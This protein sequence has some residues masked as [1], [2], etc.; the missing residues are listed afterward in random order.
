[1]V[2]VVASLHRGGLVFD[3]PGLS[4][5]KLSLNWAGVHCSLNVDQPLDMSRY[6]QKPRAVLHLKENCHKLKLSKL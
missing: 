2:S 5:Y 3:L 6:E 4:L 1:M